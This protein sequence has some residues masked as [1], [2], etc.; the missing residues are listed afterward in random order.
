MSVPTNQFQ[1]QPYLQEQRHFPFAD[2]KDLARQVDLAYIDIARNANQRTIG[3]YALNFPLVTGEKVYLAGSSQPQGV[4]RQTYTFTSFTNI[5]H[6]INLSTVTDFLSCYGSYP[7]GTNFYGVLF[8]GTGAIPNTLSFYISPTQI[9]FV[10][11]GANAINGTGV[12]V[13]QWISQ[14]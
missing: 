6:G 8:A 4:L 14:Y 1:Q 12:I 13:L 5:N 10:N 9:V 11:G 7:D 3:T 2:L